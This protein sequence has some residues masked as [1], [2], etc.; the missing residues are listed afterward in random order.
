M[1]TR[2][3]LALVG[4]PRAG[5]STSGTLA[6]YLVDE[7]AAC[8]WQAGVLRISTALR[9]PEHWPELAEQFRTADVV[10]LCSPLY[11]DS[12]PAETTRALERL[13]LTP[14]RHTQ[15]LFAVIN[16]GFVEAEQNDT[17][18]AICHL[19]SRQAGLT[20]LG[21]LALGGG[22]AVNGQSLEMV[23]KMMPH[24][25]RALKM[26]VEAINAGQPIPPEALTLIRRRFCPPWLYFLMANYGMK[27][28]ARDHGVGKQ[29]NATPYAR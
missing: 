11:V 26:T 2:T 27:K 7:L 22:G 28:S 29:I 8:G 19:F 20:W 13:V 16:S 6:Q 10:A 1:T 3:F 5:D 14:S 18:L 4:S 15:A 25:P 24:L 23:G 21:G 9:H 12:L 17:A